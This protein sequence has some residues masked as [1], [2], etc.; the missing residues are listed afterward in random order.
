MPDTT[1]PAR[2]GGFETPGGAAARGLWSHGDYVQVGSRIAAMAED[3]CETADVRGGHRILDVATGHGNVALCA[4]RREAAVV[5]IDIVPE[6]VEVARAR[7]RADGLE[8]ELRVGNAEALEFDDDSF[9]AVLSCVGVQFTVDQQAAASELVRVCRPGGRIALACW[10]PFD[11]WAE[12]PAMQA[13]HLR[14]PPGATSPM[15]WGADEGLRTLFGSEPTIVMHPRT[16]RYRSATAASYVSMMLETFPP[17]V[18]LLGQL[19]EAGRASF[20]RELLALAERWNEVG[21][22]SLV[23]PLTYAIVTIDLPSV[24]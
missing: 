14:P 2:P 17:F 19:D 22:G 4:A 9:D 6:L 11:L 24:D 7:L 23:L 13:R 15:A 8:A 16:F 1:I 21:D 20:A 10:T 12:L 5:G 18:A 3:L